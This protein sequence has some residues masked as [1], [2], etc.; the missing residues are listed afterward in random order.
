MCKT[1]VKYLIYLLPVFVAC[2]M[3]VADSGGGSEVGNG[4]V[5]GTIFNE[6]GTP[7]A[8]TQVILLPAD[9][10]PQTDGPVQ[11]AQRDTTDESGTY[12]FFF[13]D[14]EVPEFTLEAVHLT[15]RKRTYIAS[16]TVPQ[17]KEFVKYVPQIIIRDIG[18]VTFYL[19]DTINI[20]EGYIYV[21]GTTWK[22]SLAGA[23]PYNEECL[24]LTVDSIPES[25]IPGFY[26]EIDGQS[27][28]VIF[29]DTFEVFAGETTHVSAFVYWAHY[30][31]DNSLIPMA[32]IYDV[33]VTSNGNIWVATESEGVVVYDGAAWHVFDEFNSHLPN[34]TVFHISG[35][36]GGNIWFATYSGAARYDG[37]SWTT[38]NIATSQLPTDLINQIE[39]DR[40]GKLW[41]ATESGAVSY[42]GT[43]WQH[44]TP[45]N[46]GLPSEVVKSLAVDID[47]SVWFATEEGL[48]SFSNDS[49]AVYNSQ[50]SN[51]ASDYT[52]WVS[53]DSRGNK[54]VGYFWEIGL[55]QFDG[56][57]WKHYTMNDTY[58][59]DGIVDQVTE[60]S[61]GNIWVVTNLGLTRF[62]GRTWCD[63]RGKRFNHLEQQQ[64]MSIAIDKKNNKW[65]G[66]WAGSIINHGI[67]SFGPTVK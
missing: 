4:I 41:F 59:L 7:A 42:D 56:T 40:S 15:E 25:L 64:F 50:N 20:N 61:E 21:K 22:S 2:S 19:P 3:N 62:N 67:I 10:N 1:I 16:I 49:W 29:S 60:D 46:S 34:N 9:Y 45:G 24:T 12:T 53:V 63:F 31:R 26:Y 14:N 28:E 48:A 58:V 17:E 54:W 57:Q 32:N 23:V 11:D 65:L 36:P 27:Q 6:N 37:T 52:Y 51:L 66:T 55:S 13:R 43:V 39:S 33:Y 47:G 5:I 44:F 18:K 35:D 30:R 38:Y 8:G